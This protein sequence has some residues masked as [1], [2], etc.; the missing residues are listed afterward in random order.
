MKKFFSLTCRKKVPETRYF[1]QISAGG[2]LKPPHLLIRANPLFVAMAQPTP[3]ATGGH[4]GA[5]H[6]DHCLC[7]LSKKSAPLAKIVPQIKVTSLVSLKCF[8]GSVPP[9]KY[10]LFPPK[11]C[12]R[13]LL[14]ESMG[15][16]YDKAT[17]FVTKTF[18][19][20]SSLILWA[21]IKI[22]TIKSRC[23]PPP[24]KNRAPVRKLCPES[25][26]PARSPAVQ[27]GMKTFFGLPPKFKDKIILCLP[28]IVRAL[29]PRSRYSGAAPGCKID[30]SCMS[31][32]RRK[33]ICSKTPRI[34]IE[35]H[36]K[37]V[38]WQLPTYVPIKSRKNTVLIRVKAGDC[39]N[40]NFI[41]VR[42]SQNLEETNR[43]S[44]HLW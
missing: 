3:G 20:S 38:G 19:W 2:C 42:R 23:D 33:N 1:E 28:N 7:L 15:E 12:A 16:H 8:L 6:P 17:D 24:G 37:T 44:R 26:Q 36:V 25:R 18:F 30:Q 32:T 39:F 43:L 10:C 13:S 9:Q 40:N 34:S 27:F 29:R 4:F 31:I 21:W 41:C 5:M 14:D 35:K 11:H 22:R